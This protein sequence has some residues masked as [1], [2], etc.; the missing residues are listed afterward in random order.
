MGGSHVNVDEWL[1][2]SAA[3][4]AE[5]E[6]DLRAAEQ[7]VA[8]LRTIREGIQLAQQRY[9]Q[10]EQAG[11]PVAQSRPAKAGSGAGRKTRRKAARRP[12]RGH[13]D[14]C[15]KVLIATTEKQLDQATAREKLVEQG[16]ELDAEQVRN[17]FAYLVRV[18]R[19][20][21]IETGVYA[22]A[23]RNHVGPGETE[24]DV[25]AEPPV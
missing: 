7:R 10:E 21:R 14:L 23:D 8:E 5:A 1:A 11:S 22:L 24:P 4:L 17:G 18:G 2:A 13:S 16:Y 25:T 9:G 12:Q 3:E 15:Y 20:V 6:A 19:A